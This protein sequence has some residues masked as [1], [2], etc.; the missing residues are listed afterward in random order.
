MDPDANSN[1]QILRPRSPG[2]RA[3][4]AHRGLDGRDDALED[5]EEL[6][7]ADFDLSSAGPQHG[8]ANDLPHTLEHVRVAVAQLPQERGGALDV[9]QEDG[10]EAGGQRCRIGSASPDL[11]VE[12][13]SFDDEA[14]GRLHGRS[15]VRIIEHGRVVEQQRH[16]PT[17][18]LEE[19]HRLLL[20]IDGERGRLS[21]AVHVRAG[22][23][24]PVQHRQRRVSEDASQVLLELGGRADPAQLDHEATR[25]G[26]LPLRAQLAGDE[27]DGHD[28]VLLGRVQQPFLG[29]LPGR[30]VLELDLFEPGERVPDVRLVVDRQHALA[31]GVDVRERAVGKLRPFAGA[32]SATSR[33]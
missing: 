18:P 32:Q 9:G 2:Q 10:D 21:R 28:A 17:V 7:G 30:V 23:L 14:D 25:G 27:T 5:G 20:L 13:F 26:M 31:A 24:G 11:A 8:V 16:R 1:R 4:N 3:L 22:A 12:P 33:Q 29:S 6:V 15:E 19:G